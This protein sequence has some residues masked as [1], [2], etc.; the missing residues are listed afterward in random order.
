M[1]GEDEYTENINLEKRDQDLVSNVLASG[2]PL[3][4]LRP[5]FPSW[6]AAL[7]HYGK[8]Q[9]ET[10]RVGH[11][12]DTCESCGASSPE[13]TQTIRWSA[14]VYKA[15]W[16]FWSF[17]ISLITSLLA[18]T[19]EKSLCVSFT[20]HHKICRRC[21]R[22]QRIKQGLHALLQPVLFGLLIL[23]L[24]ALVPM[25]VFGAYFGWEAGAVGLLTFAAAAVILVA[26]FFGMISICSR[27][28]N[29][30]V[31]RCLRSIG[32]RPFSVSEIK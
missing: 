24:I 18:F 30:L 5:A 14:N 8:I 15:K 11:A 26:A 20:T 4:K 2:K 12:S 27:I 21:H 22:A 31:S 32:R 9:S 23:S 28:P 1:T 29:L 7:Q 16:L 3:R 19:V 17:L 6:E 25:L 10:Y 13:L